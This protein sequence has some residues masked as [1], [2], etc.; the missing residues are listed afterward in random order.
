[1]VNAGIR[2]NRSGRYWTASDGTVLLT[3]LPVDPLDALVFDL[4]PGCLQLVIPQFTPTLGGITEV[5]ASVE[6]LGAATIAGTF[7]SDAGL[8][9]FDGS[10]VPVPDVEL[11]ARREDQSF[12]SLPSGLDGSFSLDP[13]PIGLIDFQ[14]LSVGT[15]SNC[16]GVDQRT[17]LGRESVTLAAQVHCQFYRV[18]VAIQNSGTDPLPATVDLRVRS[19]LTGSVFGGPI[20]TDGTLGDAFILGDNATFSVYLDN[21]S[22]NC[23]AGSASGLA[24]IFGGTLTVTLPMHCKP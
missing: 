8:R 15:R 4:P 5:A 16:V 22:Q 6:C 20:P 9:Q 10:P 24:D 21:L 2:I 12:T 14:Y 17:I 13:A 7:T 18:R 3:Q 1:M 23:Q 19:D 11:I